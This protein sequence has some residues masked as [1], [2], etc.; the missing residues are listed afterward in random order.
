MS[1]KRRRSSK[2][3]K[4]R[5]RAEDQTPRQYAANPFWIEIKGEPFKGEIFFAGQYADNL[6]HIW[7]GTAHRMA[8]LRASICGLKV[9]GVRDLLSP[10][11]SYHCPD[12]ARV[13][14][15]KGFTQRTLD[16]ILNPL[17]AAR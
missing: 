15:E 12:C 10:Q 3:V 13:D 2:R 9:V 1:R 16:T 11:I 5:N 4:V 17:G 7:K 6:A 8:G 14:A